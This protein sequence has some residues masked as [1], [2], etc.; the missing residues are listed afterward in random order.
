MK[1]EMLI[2]MSIVIMSVAM[3]FSGCNVKTPEQVS[4]LSQNSGMFV[5]IGWISFDNPSQEEIK[6]VSSV[7]D[8]VKSKA[9][10]IQTNSSSSDAYIELVYPDIEKIIDKKIGEKYRNTAK[11]GVLSLL[12]GIDMMFIKYPEW[13][14]K[15]DFGIIAITSFVDGA[16]IGLSFDE[17]SETMVKARGIA[18]KREGIKK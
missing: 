17:K 13:K 6:A 4:A 2:A 15:Q 14:E 9:L 18:I 5:A 16:K 11:Q 10:V 7:L 1:R 3:L 8:D 12:G